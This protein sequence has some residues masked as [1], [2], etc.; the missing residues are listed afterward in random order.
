[1]PPFIQTALD[2][3]ELADRHERF[4]VLTYSS[5]IFAMLFGCVLS[6]LRVY[7]ELRNG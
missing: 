2:W 5:I 7:S 1:M 4:E 6:T 3:W